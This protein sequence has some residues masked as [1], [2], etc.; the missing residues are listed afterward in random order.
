MPGA[1]RCF[2]THTTSPWSHLLN[3]QACHMTFS[4]CHLSSVF[5][6]CHALTRVRA[7]TYSLT[8]LFRCTSFPRAYWRATLLSNLCS[9]Q[10]EDAQVTGSLPRNP[11][12][13]HSGI[14]LCLHQCPLHSL[15]LLITLTLACWHSWTTSALAE[16]TLLAATLL[17]LWISRHTCWAR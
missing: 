11:N 12:Q 16:H 14:C 7:T 4:L 17:S 5:T 3:L 9:A 10:W 13:T 8:C 6:P 1:G 2:F 15:S